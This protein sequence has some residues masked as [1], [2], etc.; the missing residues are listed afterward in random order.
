M[1]LPG[2]RF[3]AVESI[4]PSRGPIEF[5]VPGA[6]DRA[7]HLVARGAAFMGTAVASRDSRTF[8]VPR[9]SDNRAV[10]RQCTPDLRGRAWV[11]HRITE[12]CVHG[13]GAEDLEESNTYGS[14]SAF[15]ISA[16]STT[17]KCRCA[18]SCFLSSRAGR[19]ADLVGFAVRSG[20][21]ATLLEM[22]VVHQCLP[23]QL[24][25]DVIAT[26][27]RQ[28]RLAGGPGSKSG[29]LSTT[30]SRASRIT[31]SAT[32]MTSAPKPTRVRIRRALQPSA[33][34]A[35]RYVEP[36]EVDGESLR[37][38]DWRPLTSTLPQCAAR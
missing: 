13:R 12:C 5:T 15:A 22:G 7:R 4:R 6:L 10:E 18:R 11:S 9:E 34:G 19:G 28:L 33:H 23:P 27:S 25:H 16:S 21:L 2:N 14:P 1:S 37:D 20:P 17:L 36:Q 29:G 30:P 35:A 32:A 38:R 31:P 26:S 8:S 24:K 3:P